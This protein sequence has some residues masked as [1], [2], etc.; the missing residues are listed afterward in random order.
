MLQRTFRQ[1]IRRSCSSFARL[2]PQ[3]LVLTAALAF[4]GASHI[5]SLG[6]AADLGAVHADVEGSA[7]S[8][9]LWQLLLQW[10]CCKY[11]YLC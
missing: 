5:Q 8:G 11:I 7:V 6:R 3:T 1:R 4:K 9:E 2:P 10:H